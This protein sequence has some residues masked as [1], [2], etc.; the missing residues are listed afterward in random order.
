MHVSTPK[1]RTNRQVRTQLI[2]H[3]EEVY[4]M[5]FANGPHQFAS[6]GGDGSLRLFDLRQLEHSTIMYET[7]SK[8]P[9]LRVAWNKQNPN[10]IATMKQDA[11]KTTILDIRLPLHPVTELGGHSAPLTAISWAPHSPGHLCSAGDDTQSLIWNLGNLAQEEKLE[12]ILAYSAASEINN[13]EWNGVSPDW[14]GISF[15]NSLQIL[16]I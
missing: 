8:T 2:A 12:P 1:P 9:L 16:R 4:D 3:D 6:V 10:Y 13:M 15:A 5:S 7:P 14:I 11:H